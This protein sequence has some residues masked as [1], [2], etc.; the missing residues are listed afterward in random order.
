MKVVLPAPF[1][2]MMAR[3]SAGDREG[4]VVDGAE[5]VEGDGDAVD[6]EQGGHLRGLLLAEAAVIGAKVGAVAVGAAQAGGKVEEAADAL[7][8][9]ERHKDEG[10]AKHATSH[11]ST[12]LIV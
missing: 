12:H 9:K 2:P 3:S 7:G 6:L 10:E 1:G 8:R 4:Q 11:Q 5:A